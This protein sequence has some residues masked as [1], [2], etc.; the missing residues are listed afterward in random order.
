MKGA[1]AN[2]CSS[3]TRSRHHLEPTV[4]TEVADRRRVQVRADMSHLAGQPGKAEPVQSYPG[5]IRLLF[6]EDLVHP[7]TVDV[8]QARRRCYELAALRGQP[9]MIL[10]NPS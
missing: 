4:A 6:H 8:G 2:T 3:D 9:G 7:L 5:D 10:P 1:E